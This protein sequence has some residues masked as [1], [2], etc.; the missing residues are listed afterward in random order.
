MAQKHTIHFDLLSNA[1][2]SF[3]RVVEL[4]AWKEFGSNHARLKQALAGSA[5]CVELLLKARLHDKDPEL[6]W[7][8]PQKTKTVSILSAVRLL[9]KI[10]V[11]FSSDDESFLDHLRETRNN[12]QHHEWRTTEKEA[13][14]TIGNAL[15]FALAFANYE[16]GQD[17]ATV[18]KEDD[19]WTLFVSELPEFV[20]AHGK[21]LEARI[22]AQGDYPSCCDE[23]GELTVPSNDGT[24]ALCGHWQSFQE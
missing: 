8:N 5:H 17:M 20:R 21:R 10:G 13:Q 14:A 15:S 24:C 4:L 18:F 11:A 16:L 6:I 9:K 3:K 7:C 2:D 1:T 23:C 22:R 19:T 12:L